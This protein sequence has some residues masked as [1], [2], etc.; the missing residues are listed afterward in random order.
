MKT[1]KKLYIRELQVQVLKE[2]MGELERNL[3]AMTM[4]SEIQSKAIKSVESALEYQQDR[5]KTAEVA[6]G[7]IILDYEMGY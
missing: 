4:M 5:S 1:K 3:N 6:I 2:R 7:R